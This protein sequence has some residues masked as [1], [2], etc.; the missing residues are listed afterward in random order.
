[1]FK[2]TL[3]LILVFCLGIAVANIYSSLAAAE[4]DLRLPENNSQGGYEFK[5]I[6][7]NTLGRILGVTNTGEDV[8][9]LGSPGDRIKEHQILVNK[10]RVQIDLK[11]AQW[12]TFTDT[13]SMD[14]VIDAGA[15]AIEV[16]PE[17][18]DD[19]QVGDIVAYESEYADGL[20]IHR[21]AY[22]GKDEKGTYFILKGDN[23][24]T[25]D[26]G[27]IRFEQIKSV[28]VAIIY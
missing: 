10:E 12:A 23:N 24:P 9:E 11:D 21:I 13:N 8:Q 1:M 25:S 4:K 3:T 6:T 16:T 20:I 26:P 18:E 19:L 22:K 7:A 14:P 5:E 15:N 2:K 17:N 28:V 27:K